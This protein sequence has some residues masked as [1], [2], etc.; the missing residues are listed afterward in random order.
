MSD[1]KDVLIFEIEYAKVL[2]LRH[3]R[4]YGRVRNVLLFVTLFGT[5]SAFGGVL[6][7]APIASAIGGLLIAACGVLSHI[8]DPSGKRAAYEQ[9]FK[10]YARLL[11]VARGMDA[12]QIQLKLDEMRADDTE[13]VEALSYVAYN[14]VIDA[15]GL[16][17][18]AK[19]K[20]DGWQRFMARIA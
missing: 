12:E 20:L 2:C 16:D 4:L 5:G 10:R 19:Y 8:V 11:G 7:H 9:D 6:A 18:S 1:Q 17:A 3:K 15:D 13:E 14:D